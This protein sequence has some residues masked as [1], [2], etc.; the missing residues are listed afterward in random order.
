MFFLHGNCDCGDSASV[1]NNVVSKKF[2][3]VYHIIR[4]NTDDSGIVKK[5]YDTH[6]KIAHN[7]MYEV[8]MS[9]RPIDETTTI[10]ET[11]SE[12]D[13]TTI[14]GHEYEKLQLRGMF[15]LCGTDLKNAVNTNLP[16][17]S[18]GNGIFWLSTQ[19]LEVDIKYKLYVMCNI[20][21]VPYTNTI[22]FQ[23]NTASESDRYYTVSVNNP[24]YQLIEIDFI[25]KLNSANMS[26]R[27]FAVTL[28]GCKMDIIGLFYAKYDDVSQYNYTGLSADIKIA[29]NDIVLSGDLSAFELS[30]NV[31][32]ERAIP[33]VQYQNIN[34]RVAKSVNND[35]F[36]DFYSYY[37]F[38]LVGDDDKFSLTETMLGLRTIGGGIVFNTDRNKGEI[39]LLLPTGNFLI[40]D[41]AGGYIKRVDIAFLY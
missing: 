2:N 4:Y 6:L 40:P 18:Y 19:N 26:R 13:Y 25:N 15:N 35:D 24:G 28:N 36:N 37:Q 32:I 34:P 29:E 1:E 11:V 3:G 21:T 22:T 41:Y 16:A 9:C 23:L 12:N 14:T 39:I 31:P 30:Y 33:V 17:D 27:S 8:L 38:C 20:L 10:G 7:P 5:G